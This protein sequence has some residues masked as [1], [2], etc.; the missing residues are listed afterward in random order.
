MTPGAARIRTGNRGSLG[1]PG[2]QHRG[3]ARTVALKLAKNLGQP[4]IVEW[5][6][7]IRDANVRI[8]N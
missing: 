7:V 3:A 2:V 1:V 4:F 6:K 5:A 8:D